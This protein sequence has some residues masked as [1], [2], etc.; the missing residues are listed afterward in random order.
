MKTSRKCMLIN[1]EKVN[2]KNDETGEVKEMCKLNYILPVESTDRI[3]GNAIFE[4]YL[5]IENFNKLD[6]Y[7]LNPNLD[8]IY[9]E[10]ALKNGFKIFPIK[11]A[12]INLRS[13][14]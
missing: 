10:R 2:F 11:I 7:L 9:E 13:S 12:E 3:K 5:P 14:Q 6:K 8:F 4:T 1:L